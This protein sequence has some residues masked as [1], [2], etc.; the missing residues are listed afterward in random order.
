MFGKEDNQKKTRENTLG[1]EY[2]QADKI[3]DIQSRR[4][5]GVSQK[6]K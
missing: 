2:T 4:E 1:R 3:N 6:Y 5:Y